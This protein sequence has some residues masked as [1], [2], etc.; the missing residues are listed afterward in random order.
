MTELREIT[1][2]FRINMIPYAILSVEWVSENKREGVE[3][4]L[5]RL[6]AAIGR[7]DYHHVADVLE[8]EISPLYRA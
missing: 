2:L 7:G 4:P 8:Y 3:S 6:Y 5:A 1:R